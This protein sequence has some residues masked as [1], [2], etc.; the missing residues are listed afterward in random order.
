MSNKIWD[1]RVGLYNIQTGFVR[2]G[3]NESLIV[4]YYKQDKMDVFI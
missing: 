4:A 2:N 1:K 3:V